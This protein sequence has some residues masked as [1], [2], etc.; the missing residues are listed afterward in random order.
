M[1]TGWS[2]VR[3]DACRMCLRIW[4]IAMA[5]VL[6][7]LL[8]ALVLLIA[9]GLEWCVEHLFT[10]LHNKEG[11]ALLDRYIHY[12]TLSMLALLG[13]WD[14]AKQSERDTSPPC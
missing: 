9:R 3:S 6:D 14:I 8:A 12:G 1:P 10:D 7:A 5:L 2:T 4:R 13:L 11:F